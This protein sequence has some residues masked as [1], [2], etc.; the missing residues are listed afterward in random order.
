MKARKHKTRPSIL[1]EM[2]PGEARLVSALLASAS[3]AKIVEHDVVASSIAQSSMDLYRAS[4]GEGPCTAKIE[5]GIV[6]YRL[7]VE[8]L[9][10]DTMEDLIKKVNEHTRHW[11]DELVAADEEDGDLRR[12]APQFA[13]G[14]P[15]L[16]G[17]EPEFGSDDI[18]SGCLLELTLAGEEVLYHDPIHTEFLNRT[19]MS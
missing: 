6:G 5:Y 18:L 12:Y 19:S 7:C 14:Y 8:S 1:V 2:T 3:N 17:L 13:N 10:G 11:I 4:R 16:G 9:E 15:G